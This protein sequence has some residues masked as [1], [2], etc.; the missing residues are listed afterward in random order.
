MKIRPI[1]RILLF[2]LVLMLPTGAAPPAAAWSDTTERAILAR[3]LG[4]MPRSLRLVLT[5]HRDQLYRGAAGTGELGAMPPDRIAA[6]C[7]KTV[8][9]IREQKPFPLIAR[10]LGRVGALTANTA[11]PYLA[12]AGDG[13]PAPAHRGFEMFTERMLHLIPFV[14]MNGE[15]SARQLLLSGRT[16][17]A[18]YLRQGLALSAA[19]TQRL[20]VHIPGRTGKI[21]PWAGFDARSTPFGVASVCVSRGAT[22]VSAVWQWIWEQAGGATAAGVSP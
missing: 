22:R 18:D 19:Y 12:A 1:Q 4:T 9:M 7:Q 5:N 17:P 21:R 20:E 10:Q 15:G 11:D 8:R 6:E 13:R 16:D 14:L 3:A 2:L